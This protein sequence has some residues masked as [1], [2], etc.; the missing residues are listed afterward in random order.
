LTF[1]RAPSEALRANSPSAA[2]IATVCGFGFCRTATSTKP[3]VKDDFGSG[4]FG[5]TLK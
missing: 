1:S 4:P 2:T 3:L 5:A